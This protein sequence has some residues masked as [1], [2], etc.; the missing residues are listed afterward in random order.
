[1]VGDI[2]D[3]VEA[4]CRAGCRSVHLDVGNETVWHRTPNRVP[5][6][7]APNLLEGAEAILASVPSP[8]SASAGAQRDPASTAR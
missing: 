3:D 6:H 4:G 8:S 1:M 2:L 5:T 7:T